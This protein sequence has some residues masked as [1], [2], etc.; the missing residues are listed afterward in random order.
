MKHLVFRVLPF[1]AVLVLAACSEN[2]QNKSETNHD[3]HMQASPESNMED[4][5]S[6]NQSAT[7]KDDKLNAVYQHYV[8]LTTAL[9]NADV[10]EAKV[11]ANAIVAGAG[12]MNNATGIV[13]PATAITN[14]DNIEQQRTA[15]HD[16]SKE[17]ISRLKA[18]GM[19]KGE[20]YVEY[21]PMA[22]NDKGASWV[23]SSKEIRNPYFGEKM[24]TCGEVKET[25]K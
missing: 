17:M 15:Y 1:A 16:L 21:C 7:I 9:T 2:N 14:S 12:T 11:A 24:M 6:G 10:S 5:H 19:E 20:L 22:F 3:G 8:H 4:M 18:A 25:I 23:S 13:N